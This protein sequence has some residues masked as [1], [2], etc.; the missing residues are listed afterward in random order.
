M[1]NLRDKILSLEPSDNVDTKTALVDGV[2]ITSQSARKQALSYIWAKYNMLPD[3]LT[4][5]LG[6]LYNA[7]EEVYLPDKNEKSLFNYTHDKSSVYSRS[8]AEKNLTVGNN[9]TQAIIS[10]TLRDGYEAWYKKAYQGKNYYDILNEY[11]ESFGENTKI[12][13][14]DDTIINPQINS[15]YEVIDYEKEINF[16]YAP[17]T[18][19]T[20]FSKEE[21]DK[22]NIT[23]PKWKAYKNKENG[24]EL[25]KQDLDEW[26]GKNRKEF[27]KNKKDAKRLYEENLNKQNNFIKE[28]KTL[29]TKTAKLFKENKIDSIISQPYDLKPS[30][31]FTD[32]SV[33]K[34]WGRSRGRNLEN[35][36]PDVANPFCRVWTVYDQ[37]GKS[38]NTLIRPFSNNMGHT[39]D[40]EQSELIQFFRSENGGEYLHD[41]S[42]LKN[43]FVKITPEKTNSAKYDT[44]RCMFSIENLAWKDVRL[45]DTLSN[46]QIGPNGGRIMWFPPYDLQ[47]QET[48]Q[49]NWNETNFIGRGEPIYTYTNTKRTGTLSFTL[50]I[51]HPSIMNVFENRK[52]VKTDYEG[53]GDLLRFF[54]GCDI[55]MKLD[56]KFVIGENEDNTE[57]TDMYT[58]VSD[59]YKKLKIS[60]YFPNNYSGHFKNVETTDDDWAEY[61]FLGK[62][63]NAY[64]DDNDVV[65][66]YEI[67]EVSGIS[68]NVSSFYSDE[69]DDGF[70]SYY[71][72]HDKDLCQVLSE[73][74]LKDTRSFKLNNNGKNGDDEVI[75]FGEL[76]T[77]INMDKDYVVQHAKNMGIL[78][79]DNTFENN[80]IEKLNNLGYYNLKITGF[81]TSQ[82][83]RNSNKLA[84]RRLG[85]V[86]EF[87]RQNL[88]GEVK[89]IITGIT[90]ETV[91]GKDVNSKE[92]KEGRRVDIEIYYNLPEI[93]GNTWVL[94]QTAEERKEMILTRNTTATTF[95]EA[96]YFQNLEKLD[97]YTYKK[98]N[99]KIKYFDPAYHSINPEGFNSRLTFLQQCTRQGH[100][101]E[102][103]DNATEN[104]YRTAGNVAFGRP[105]FCVLRIGDFIN[106]KILIRSV[107]IVYQ[108]GNGMQWDMN[109]EG[110]GVQPMFAKVTL[111]IEIIGGQSLDAPVSRLNNAVSFNYYANTGVYDNR[112]DRAIYDG[113]KIKYSSLYEP[114]IKTNTPSS[115]RE[116]NTPSSE[117]EGHTSTR[118]EGRGGGFWNALRERYDL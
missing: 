35:K 26:K 111:Q 46:D 34:L 84:K 95:N 53:D 48:S 8:I 60:I 65:I 77:K 75:S 6:R 41:Y 20:Q 78:K 76:F 58:V 66:G 50:L 68:T 73:N 74:N 52:D 29:L 13:Y 17:L 21:W 99:E 44:K 12:T 80:V 103:D 16:E 24:K 83:S 88:S 18:A 100:T 115:E 56:D 79:S 40:V 31:R 114:Q 9:N 85:V 93:E 81:A 87:L 43:G 112:A 109:P 98:I 33:N 27:R 113:R 39:K 91:S 82:D 1:S 108:N 30:Y 15:E 110:I 10:E 67:D 86:E 38:R 116:T 25:Y 62:G 19:T 45:S 63:V 96:D 55:P 22:I 42:V 70:T 59:E 51:D 47:F 71:Y 32:T 72:R 14:N 90:I 105:P 4:Q 61:L 28:P 37:Y 57:P 97:S 104:I 3:N 49:A 102:L 107:N 101:L 36:T 23:K 89:N 94:N 106:T 64:E 5:S 118:G 11:S 7:V 54:A 92:S 117:R 69:C 2:Y